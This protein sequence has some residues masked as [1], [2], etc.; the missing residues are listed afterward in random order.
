M[1]EIQGN[2]AGAAKRRVI[3]D[4]EDHKKPPLRISH[5]VYGR[6]KRDKRVYY[7]VDPKGE[8]TEKKIAEQ[9]V[10]LRWRKR[11]FPNHTFSGSRLSPGVWRTL[12]SVL[13]S[14]PTKWLQASE[15]E[16]QSQTDV[17][18]ESMRKAHQT[19]PAANVLLALFVHCGVQRLEKIIKR[20]NDPARVENFG[21]PDLFLY[22]TENKSGKVAIARFVEV[23]KPEEDLST[24]QKEEI[25]FLQS[26]GLHARVLR[27]IERE[28][29]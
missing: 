8:G 11:A 28:A 27:L 25:T 26:L 14:D 20:H 16:I 6:E 1:S 9:V 3:K 17:R 22:A 18:R 10:L 19:L 7:L 12:P 24:D 4:P 2:R 13:G 21:T 5:I 15:D 23:K 29:A